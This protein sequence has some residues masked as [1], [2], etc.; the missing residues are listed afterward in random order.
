MVGNV[1]NH[2]FCVTEAEFS[3]YLKFLIA[4]F[5]PCQVG[6]RGVHKSMEQLGFPLTNYL[7]TV[8]AVA[9]R[10]RRKFC[11]CHIKQGGCGGVVVHWHETQHLA[12]VGKE[13]DMEVGHPFIYMFQDLYGGTYETVQVW[14]GLRFPHCPP[15]QFTYENGNAALI[16]VAAQGTQIIWGNSL[17]YGRHGLGTVAVGDNI[18][19]IEFVEQRY[20]AGLPGG[21]EI[22][23]APPGSV[24]ITLHHNAGIPVLY[25]VQ[26]NYLTLNKHPV[27]K[28]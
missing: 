1:L 24:G 28:C 12:Q 9:K 5:W 21:P 11:S 4:A 22:K 14:I 15:Q 13:M 27:T 10:V 26:Y 2:P 16:D 17:L 7:G 23:G 3:I 6:G 18:Q 20:V 8:N 19:N 25:C